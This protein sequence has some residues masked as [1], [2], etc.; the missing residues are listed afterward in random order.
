MMYY[1]QLLSYTSN[2]STLLQNDN[3]AWGNRYMAYL[4][5]VFIDISLNRKP[6]GVIEENFMGQKNTLG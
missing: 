2:N 1:Q 3:K 6:L 5:S 4:F